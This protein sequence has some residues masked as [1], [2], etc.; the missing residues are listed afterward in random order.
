MFIF[1]VMCVDMFILDISSWLLGVGFLDLIGLGESVSGY[2]ILELLILVIKLINN[3]IGVIC[4]REFID[5][6]GIF[7]VWENW[8]MFW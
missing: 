4:F 7:R 2:L 5:V 1:D 8:C 6:W 3:S